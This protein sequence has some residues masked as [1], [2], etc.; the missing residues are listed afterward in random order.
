LEP[1]TD[2]GRWTHLWRIDVDSKI[3]KQVTDSKLLIDGFDVTPDGT[4]V[5]FAARSDNRGNFPFMSELFVVQ[6]DGSGLSRLTHNQAMEL[7]PIWAPDGATIAFHASDDTSFELRSGYLWVMN[8]DTGELEKLEG[9]NTGEID[10][11]VW[12]PDGKSL[13]FNEVHGT[14]SNLY[15]IDVATG[16]LEAMTHA[17]GTLRVESYSRDRTKIAYVFSDCVTPPDLYFA[18]VHGGNP[19]RLTRANPWVEEEILLPSC[20]VIQWEGHDGLGVEGICRSTAG[21]PVFGGTGSSR[22]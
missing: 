2:D 13:L 6:A 17:T 9:Q 11:L 16:Q 10:Q 20:R 19:V 21:R 14:N 4:R 15:R 5:V 18:D 8:P 7:D 12:T 3:V 1:G 22:I